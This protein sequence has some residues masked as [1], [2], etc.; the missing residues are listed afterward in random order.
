MFFLLLVYH[1]KVNRPSSVTSPAVLSGCGRRFTVNP[2]AVVCEETAAGPIKK[3]NLVCDFYFFTLPFSATS[4]PLCGFNT[5]ILLRV[6]A[7]MHTHTHTPGLS[8]CINT[9]NKQLP[10]PLSS[11]LV[12]LTCTR[13]LSARLYGEFVFF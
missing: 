1:P 13:P 2:P 3:R 9:A 5:S 8:Q 10:N 4:A 7:H 6:H 12:L 11:L